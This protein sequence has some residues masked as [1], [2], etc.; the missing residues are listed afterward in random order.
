M[1]PLPI[2]I[3]L[4]FSPQLRGVQ[5][6][7]GCWLF[8]RPPFQPSYWMMLK[9]EGF[10]G[11]LVRNSAE[12]DY[13]MYELG[14]AFVNDFLSDLSRGRINLEGASDW[15]KRSLFKNMI[16]SHDVQVFR[17]DCEQRF[18][19]EN[20]N[21]SIY[22]SPSSDFAMANDLVAHQRHQLADEL[23]RD[24]YHRW[25]KKEREDREHWDRFILWR[26]AIESYDI[27]AEAV[28][29]VGD[30]L[31][32]LKDLGVFVIDIAY[33]GAK[34]YI[35]FTQ[36][37]HRL[38]HQAVSGDIDAIKAEL[39]QMGIVLD[40]H[41]NDVRTLKAKLDEGKQLFDSLMSDAETR[42]LLFDYLDSL[43]QSIPYRQ[44]RTIW[45]R[46]GFEIGLEVLLAL[47]T[48]GL[49][50]AARSAAKSTRVVN[51]TKQVA[52]TVKRIGPFTEQAIQQLVALAK[53][54][55]KEQDIPNIKPVKPLDIPEYARKKTPEKRENNN[56]KILLESVTPHTELLK[57]Q[58][59][60][61]RGKP[62][63]PHQNANADMIRSL[64][65]QNESAEILSNRGLNVTHLPNTGRKG[66][67][68]DLDINTRPADVYSPKSKNPNTIRDNMIHKVEH[69]APDI[70]L[71]ITDSPLSSTDMLKFLD[72]KPV[73]GLQNLYL[74]DGENV[75]LRKF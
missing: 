23:G 55:R 67:N 53:L 14:G 68:P 45:M 46:A 6:H 20:A 41:I 7:S 56:D 19:L 2:N 21:D 75:L 32:S 33:A 63:S 72:E 34:T 1:T 5:L 15:D 61:L 38:L 50:L 60:T 4:I 42:L 66:G 26:E 44:S 31:V 29:T 13:L 54:L 11:G 27:A 30:M 28:D 58:P 74:I 59:G 35:K 57:V 37:Y 64:D 47:A 65:R 18:R 22:A 9:R 52:K 12:L 24:I 49:A 48:G 8:A 71:N 70:V 10:S 62:E 17:L 43:Y 36:Q 73:N 39:D 3:P 25:L 40:A 16:F 69:Q 51:A